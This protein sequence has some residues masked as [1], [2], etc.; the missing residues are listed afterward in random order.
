MVSN[1]AS[2]PVEKRVSTHNLFYCDLNHR[3]SSDEILEE[4]KQN[5]D[6]TKTEASPLSF[7]VLLDEL[8]HRKGF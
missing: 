1:I 6:M 4:L 2:P 5:V 8:M 3:K 7:K